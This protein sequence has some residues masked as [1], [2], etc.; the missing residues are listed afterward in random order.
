MNILGFASVIDKHAS[1]AGDS[2]GDIA[3]KRRQKGIVTSDQ[4]KGG[5]AQTRVP[6]S[7]YYEQKMDWLQDLTIFHF[8]PLTVMARCSQL[9]LRLRRELC[10]SRN[11][12]QTAQ[13]H[14]G[15]IAQFQARRDPDWES[16]SSSPA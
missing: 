3:R 15:T 5:V 8:E 12:R 7:M 10:S 13:A 1:L 9:G 16:T 2:N 14:L 4:I 6:C 11:P